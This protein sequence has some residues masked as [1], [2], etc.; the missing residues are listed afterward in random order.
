MEKPEGLTRLGIPP[1]F[2]SGYSDRSEFSMI[3]KTLESGHGA[4][5]FGPNG[6]GKTYLGCSVLRHYLSFPGSRRIVGCRLTHEEIVSHYFKRWEAPPKSLSAPLL[7]L[8]EIG[9]EIIVSD[10]QR[11]YGPLLEKVLRHRFDYR[12]L[13]V[14]ASNLK[15]SELGNMYGETVVSYIGGH[16]RPFQITGKDL[17]RA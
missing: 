15:L 10:K 13:T 2:Q 12:L 7:F 16:C 6:T 17:R 1:L 8:D 3:L 5:L 4:Y 9:K 14:L 11:V